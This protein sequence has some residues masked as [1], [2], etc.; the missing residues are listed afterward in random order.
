MNNYPAE[1]LNDAK[2]IEAQYGP[3]NE[4]INTAN[5]Q[6]LTGVFK[7]VE[8]GRSMGLKELRKCNFNVSTIKCLEGHKNE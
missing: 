7:C 6:R 3:M 2:Y 1:N 8:C 4:L 5:W